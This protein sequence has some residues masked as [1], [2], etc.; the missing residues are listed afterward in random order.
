MDKLKVLQYCLGFLGYKPSLF[1]FNNKIYISVNGRHFV[2]HASTRT[3]KI[4]SI[5]RSEVLEK[6]ELLF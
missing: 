3:R 4:V 2:F 1:L 5:L 6:R